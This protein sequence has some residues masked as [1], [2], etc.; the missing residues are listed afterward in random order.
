MRKPFL[1]L[2]TAYPEAE[3]TKKPHKKT[4]LTRLSN[5]I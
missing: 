3:R 2:F 4:V 1:R 5:P